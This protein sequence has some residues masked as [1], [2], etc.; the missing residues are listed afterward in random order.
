LKAQAAGAASLAGLPEDELPPV[1][2]VP[3]GSRLPFP[4]N[5]LFVG[6]TQDLL[7]LAK[8]LKAGEIAAIGQ[9][10][11]ATGWAASARP[12]WLLSSPTATATIFKAASS[13]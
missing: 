12:N 13:G 8:A 6:R 3:P 10:A 9:V 4:R 7:S 5:P 11:A 1:A 2:A